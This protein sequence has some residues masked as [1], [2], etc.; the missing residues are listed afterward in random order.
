MPKS[1]FPSFLHASAIVSKMVLVVEADAVEVSNHAAAGLAFDG[2]IIAEDTGDRGTA[3][4]QL[5]GNI[6]LR[7]FVHADSPLFTFGTAFLF[8]PMTTSIAIYF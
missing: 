3:D 4:P 2:G 8:E 7:D 6:R 1:A 5:S